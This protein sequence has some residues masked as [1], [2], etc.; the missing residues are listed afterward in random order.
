ML[1][2]S[3]L[4][5]DSEPE[6]DVEFNDEAAE[7]LSTSARLPSSLESS[8]RNGGGGGG[9]GGNELHEFGCLSIKKFRRWNES[10]P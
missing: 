1:S 6:S 9:G 7:E 4:L 10:I 2:S 8:A 3:L 5:S